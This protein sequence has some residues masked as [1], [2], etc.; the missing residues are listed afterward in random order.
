[1]MSPVA[2]QPPLAM[3]ILR[4]FLP[5][6][7][8]YFLSYLFRTVNA[9]LAPDLAHAVTLD[10][11]QLGLLTS[12]YFIAFASTQLPLGV[13]LDRF[14]PRRVESTLLLVA[15]TGA[16]CFAVADSAVTLI[17][18]RALIGF[19]VSA[20][21]MAAFKANVLWFPRDRLPL[22]NG[23]MMASGGL[24]A[25]AATAPVEAALRITDWRGVFA[26]LAV[27]TVAVSA[28][29]FAAVPERPL[30]SSGERIGRQ[31][32]DIATIFGSGLFWRLIPL[33]TLS[34]AT[35]M[36]IQG[37]WAGPWLRDVGGLDR[38][39]AAGYLFVAAAA[40]VAGF[41]LG[42][43][44]ADRLA[45]LGVA[46]LTVAVTGM[47]MFMLIQ[48]A[49]VAGWFEGQA[50][51]WAAFGFFGTSG[52]LTY[53][54]L[55]QAFPAALAGRVNTALNLMVFIASF[56]VQAGIGAIVALWVP[57]DGRYPVEAYQ[58]AFG[59]V[60]ILQ[61]V[62]LLWLGISRRP[63]AGTQAAQAE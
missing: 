46:P 12:A 43:L 18:G 48:M 20:C 37:L 52:T 56:L 16:A 47:S 22:V 49:V 13:M 42:G 60:L 32:R 28:V 14:G 44:I 35:F 33:P 10:A 40:M 25:L 27:A 57:V 38:G 21:L 6:A 9:V 36:S 2:P 55:T 61:L 30:P 8:G 58:S 41:V 59:A 63:R 39:A 5:F 26:G 1:M 51:I 7:A 45:R 53:A 31:V 11:G 17:I 62:A 24:G 34:Q 23:L 54:V 15:A 3:L 29:L 4:I 50:W 19:G